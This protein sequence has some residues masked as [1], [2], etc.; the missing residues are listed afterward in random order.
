MW[1]GLEKLKMDLPHEPATSLLNIYTKD[2][3]H[4]A[5]RYPLDHSK[6]LESAWRD[7]YLK[8]SVYTYKT[9]LRI[10][11]KD[12]IGEGRRVRSRGY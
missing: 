5:C 7:S 12:K 1:K 2:P 6:G 4:G 9:L 3:V 11:W 10:K 8:C